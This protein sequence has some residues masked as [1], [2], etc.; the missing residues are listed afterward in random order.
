MDF[1]DVIDLF[2]AAKPGQN[3]FKCFVLTTCLQFRISFS[4]VSAPKSL[5]LS[6]QLIK[7]SF[8]NFYDFC[9]FKF[10]IRTKTKVSNRTG[11]PN[12]SGAPGPMLS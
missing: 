2:I 12:F 8:S 6:F 10:H 7:Y 3:C 4:S 9:I 11:A 5:L 1:T